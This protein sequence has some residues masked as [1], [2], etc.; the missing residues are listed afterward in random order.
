SQTKRHTQ[1]QKKNTIEEASR[2]MTEG[3][4]PAKKSTLELGRIQGK[5]VRS[6]T[7]VGGWC[8]SFLLLFV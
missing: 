5:E 6:R 7:V 4:F 3:N 2:A 1:I 8:D